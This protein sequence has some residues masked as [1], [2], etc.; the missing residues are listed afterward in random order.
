MEKHEHRYWPNSRQKSE[1][2]LICGLNPKKE[3]NEELVE[4]L[5]AEIDYFN[6]NGEV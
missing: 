4:R 2:C 6:S 1:V 3:T 5:E